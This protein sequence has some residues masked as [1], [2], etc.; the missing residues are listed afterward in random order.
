MEPGEDLKAVVHRAIEK[1]TVTP[2]TV[3]ID[4]E[5]AALFPGLA[6]GADRVAHTIT[7]P[8]QMRR[9][10]VEAKIMIPGAKTQ[11]INPDEN[12]TRLMQR[13]HQ[14]WRQLVSEP[15]C[16]VE[17]L[18]RT[19]GIAACEVTRFLPLAFLAPDIVEAVLD[20]RQ[21]VELNVQKLKKLGAIPADWA[22]QRRLLGVCTQLGQP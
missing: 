8:F 2:G 17:V 10:G 21:P 11:S 14:W 15:S 7:L 18:A 12:L 9:R 5:L 3:L 4:L 20:G 16:N 13:S 19:S 6:A 22:E 1:I